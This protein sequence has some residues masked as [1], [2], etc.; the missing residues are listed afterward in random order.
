MLIDAHTG[1]R[2]GFYRRPPAYD[3]RPD[4]LDRAVITSG[5]LLHVDGV[6]AAAAARAVGWA[7]EAGDPD[8]D[9]RRA[10]GGGIDRVWPGVDLLACNPRFLAQVTGRA[11][12]DR[13]P[14]ARRSAGPPRVAATLADGGRDSASR[15]AAFVRAPGFPVSVVD[16]NGAGD[17]FHGACAVGGAAR[18]GRSNGRSCSPTRVAADEMPHARGRRAIPR[19]PE[20]AESLG[21][22]GYREARRGV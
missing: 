16:T 2:T 14:R 22:R 8:H 10:R 21:A 7:R 12:L 11:E 1:L 5:R 19:L 4:E 13:P 15:R 18:A 20:V 6:D 17:V 9:G 3:I